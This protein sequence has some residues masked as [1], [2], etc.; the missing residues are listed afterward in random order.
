MNI[1]I[2]LVFGAFIFIGLQSCANG[3]KA[4]E[5]APVVFQAPFYTIT[6][7]VKSGEEQ[8]LELFLPL[9][10][11]VKPSVVLD[12]VYFRGRSAKLESLSEDSEIL[13]GRFKKPFNQG[14]QDRIMSS[15][16]REE[17]GNKPPVVLKDF[18]YDL[19]P[20]Q[21]IISYQQKGEIKHFKVTGI[22]K[23]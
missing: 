18:P 11:Q 23:Q 19:Q 17:Y 9:N 2:K 14:D 8:L 1:Y 21:A 5:G 7:T 4:R 15:D 22:Q 20:D 13:V 6:K 16:P 12:S 3:K 10:S